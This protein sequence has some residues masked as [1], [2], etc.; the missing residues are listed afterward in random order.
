[1]N[2]L[3]ERRRIDAEA[4]TADINIQRIPVGS[5]IGAAVLI[6]ILLAG[7]FLDVPGVRG[8]VIW[9]GGIGLVL[10]I[11]LIWWRSRWVRR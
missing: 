1:L 6:V 7:L 5:S 4:A 8:T 2:D 11:A 9:G 3:C 10:G